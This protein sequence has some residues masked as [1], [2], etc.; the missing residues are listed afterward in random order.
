[1]QIRLLALPVLVLSLL[2][3]ACQNPFSGSSPKVGVVDLT[4]L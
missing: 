4:V 1:M 2:L 3:G